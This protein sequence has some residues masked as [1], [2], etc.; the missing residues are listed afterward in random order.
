MKNWNFDL[1]LLVSIFA[2]IISVSVAVIEYKSNKKFKK[3]DV[4]V[5]YY[6]EVFKDFLLVK[7]PDCMMKMSHD[8]EQKKLNADLLKQTLKDIRKKIY[9]LQFHNPDAYHVLYQ[10]IQDLEDYLVLHI[11]INDN[12][13]YVQ[14]VSEIQTKLTDVYKCIWEDV[15]F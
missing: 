4:S 12:I 2:L 7:I 6:D 14:I 9:F 13:E 8:T 15:Y 5:G 3:I 10:K 11:N 1:E